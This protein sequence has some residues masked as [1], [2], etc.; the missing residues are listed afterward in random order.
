MN[1]DDQNDAG[2]DDRIA[3]L[4]RRVA[5]LEQ[6]ARNLRDFVGYDAGR[7]R[8]TLRDKFRPKMVR[9]HHYPPRELRVPP[10]Y[11]ETSAAQPLPTI[12]I[13]SP[14]FNQAQYIGA[15]IDSV[16]D[17]N[18]PAL[19]FHV[20]DGCSA[21][22][23]LDV[24]RR[25]EGRITWDSVSDKGQANAVNIGFRAIEGD[26]MAYLNSDDVLLPGSLD[27]VARV[28]AANPDVDVVYG[29]RICLDEEG[30]EIGRWILPQHDTETIK[31]FD[32]IP[33][34]TMFWRRRAWDEVGDIDES[35]DY[36]LDWDFILRMQARGM[37][38]KRV[39]RFL[40]GFRVH[41][42]QKTTRNATVGAEESRRLRQT[43]LG[44]DPTPKQI[45]KAI[46]GY[47]RRHVLYHRLYKLKLLR[48]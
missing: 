43:H 13:V 32:Y 47:L 30:K 45:D 39:P 24:L 28:F 46:A 31:W 48:Y 8:E 11:L 17:Q 41:E 36:A 5:K 33:Q 7:R 1:R 23:T 27:Y 35:F 6:E 44:F 15:T 19:R 12:A 38:F 34:E 16:V 21:D 40:S 10:E 42:A 29:H 25:Y 9:F 37:Q 3:A 22:D 20:Q 18:Y 14:S 26:I 4:E 2:S